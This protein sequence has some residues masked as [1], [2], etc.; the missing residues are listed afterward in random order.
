MKKK[1]EHKPTEHCG[2]VGIYSN[3]SNRHVS[4]QVYD[5][6]LALQHRGQESAGIFTNAANRITG[7]KDM[8]LVNQVFTNRI[9]MGL[10]GSVAIGHVRYGTTGSS[11]L[12]CAQ[13]FFFESHSYGQNFAL[14]FNGTLTNFIK[15]KKKYRE[16]GHV[17]AT[18]TDTEVIAHIIAKN[19]L[20]TGND[21]LQALES[22]MNELDGSYSL[23]LLNEKNE[24]FGL[25]DP[26][27][28]KP[29]AL[30]QVKDLDL[31]VIASESVAIDALEGDFIRNIEPGEIIK[32][33]KTGINS[34]QVFDFPEHAFC[35]F[36][37]VYFARP[38]SIFNGR[39]V[40]E[41]REKLG[42]NLARNFPVDADL[43]VPVPDSGRTAAT[44]Y[45]IESRIPLKEGLI[46]NR[47]IHRTFIMP[48]QNYREI[49]VRYKL[50]PIRSVIEGKNLVLVD[51]SIVR[52][53]TTKR[54]IRMLKKHGAKKVHIR[55]SCPP[56]LNSCYMGIDFPT[57]SELIAPTKTMEEI[58]QFL[59]AD[60]LYYQ[61]IDG[62]LEAIG[63]PESELCT[64]CLTGKYK[65]RSSINLSELEKELGN[66]NL[67]F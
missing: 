24:L 26:F 60:S 14:A 55:I 63:L 10:F 33:D 61:T 38:D 37:F 7:Y 32:I 8:G 19:L 18:S 67:A 27:G 21:Y 34:K 50:N 59:D 23:V 49:A 36:E 56:I 4:K 31:L 12:E 3:V 11:N 6:L 43:V 5:V 39:C 22:S 9:L 41:V 16:M 64:A 15:L 17:F 45:S 42:R 58:Q 48:G 30:G 57:S 2:V 20:K 35:M 54:I 29:L 47:Y 40:Y 52:G 25:R 65:L 44:G 46:K 1:Y 51:D 66:Q 62:L 13:P 28:F 53:T